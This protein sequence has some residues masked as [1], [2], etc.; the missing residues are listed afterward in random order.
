MTTTPP[1]PFTPEELEKLTLG[2]VNTPEARANES[3]V[4]ALMRHLSRVQ[5]HLLSVKVKGSRR[6][7]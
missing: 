6:G 5:G 7:S 1:E 4:D 3:E 2:L